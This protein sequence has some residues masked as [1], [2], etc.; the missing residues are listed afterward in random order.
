MIP[1]G[2]GACQALS[3]HT[4]SPRVEV[5]SSRGSENR[6]GLCTW[7]FS[8]AQAPSAARPGGLL[9]A[10]AGSDLGKVYEE[11]DGKYIQMIQFE[12]GG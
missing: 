6:Q 12:G 2:Q 9:L 4:L 10:D 1:W 5:P 3:G 8:W 11:V 7:S